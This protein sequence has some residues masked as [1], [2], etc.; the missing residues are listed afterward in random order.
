MITSPVILPNIEL[1]KYGSN[2]PESTVNVLATLPLYVPAADKP[3]PAVKALALDATTPVK[4]EPSPENDPVKYVVACVVPICWF[5]PTCNVASW[6]VLPETITFFHSA[7][8]CFF[9]F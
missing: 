8:L 2:D 3:L 1:E 6:A 9:F 7:M 5:E 4:P